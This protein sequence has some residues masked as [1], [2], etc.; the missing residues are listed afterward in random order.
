M[1][2]GK[3][4]VWI[5]LLVVVLAAV[6]AG[7]LYWLSTPQAP[8]TEGFLIRNTG[9][10]YPVSTDDPGQSQCSHEQSRRNIGRSQHSRTPIIIEETT[11][12]TA[13]GTT[14]SE[15]AAGT[16]TAETASLRRGSAA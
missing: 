15:T 11:S 5:C 1:R 13:A 2:D 3:K 14:I 12:E 6:V 7:L 9:N 4:K 10:A 8:S 16:T